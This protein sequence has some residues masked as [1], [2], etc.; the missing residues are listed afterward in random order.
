VFSSQEAVDCKEP[1]I[2][3]THE[4]TPDD[5]KGMAAAV[6]I[7]TKTGGATSHAAV[8][9]RAMDKA[10]VV[11][12]TALDLMWLKTSTVKKVT[13]D[14]STGKVWYDD[15]V[16]VIDASD[17]PEIRA[18]MDYALTVE[19]CSEVVTLDTEDP[20][21]Q[22]IAASH[23][24][25]Q[26]DVFDSVLDNLA[27]MTDRTHVTLDIRRPGG[28]E[29]S[30]LLHSCFGWEKDDGTFEAHMIGRLVDRK[31]ELKGIR[32]MASTKFSSPAEDGYKFMTVQS[33]PADY[34]VFKQLA[35]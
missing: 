30:S 24:W 5:I 9:A 22:T 13:I 10:C 14:G 16:P 8:V 19:D 35:A 25:G 15:E 27:K 4:T 2:L 29:E 17:A 28:F 1:C 6:G 34:A 33:V 26:T 7:L 18:F 23:W 32:I 21:I 31:D 3:V 11:G 12:T 20:R